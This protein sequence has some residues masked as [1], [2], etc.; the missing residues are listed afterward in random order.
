MAREQRE[1][2]PHGALRPAQRRAHARTVAP[3]CRA[4]TDPCWRQ[5]AVRQPWI[6]RK[7]PKVDRVPPEL[8]RN[9]EGTTDKLNR[10]NSVLNMLPHHTYSRLCDVLGHPRTAVACQMVI[11]DSVYE[12]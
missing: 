3:C 4:C 5:T 8:D 10:R 6:L 7:L 11:Q 12:L 9:L 1:Q 2:Q